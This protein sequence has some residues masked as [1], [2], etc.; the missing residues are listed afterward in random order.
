MHNLMLH[1]AFT[2]TASLKSH[3]CPNSGNKYKKL[4]QLKS[5]KHYNVNSWTIYH[6]LHWHGYGKFICTRI[7]WYSLWPIPPVI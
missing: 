5:Y 4:A 3:P 6:T 1:T 7:M 2:I